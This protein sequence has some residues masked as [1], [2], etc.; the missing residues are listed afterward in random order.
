MT[1]RAIT[2]SRV[3][4]ALSAGAAEGPHE[5]IAGGPSISLRVGVRTLLLAPTVIGAAARIGMVATTDEGPAIDAREAGVACDAGTGIDGGIAIKA[6]EA[7]IGIVARRDGGS[8]VG[9]GAGVV[10]RRGPSGV[11]GAGAEDSPAPPGAVGA[12]AC[13]GLGTSP[14][15]RRAEAKGGARPAR[16]AR[17]SC[18]IVRASG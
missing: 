17:T 6:R 15:A 18:C 16:T 14:A 12:G 2:L 5:G 11:V 10:E 7:G 1:P 9:G 3:F 13:G 4:R 8:G